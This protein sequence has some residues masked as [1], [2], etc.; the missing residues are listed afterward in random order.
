MILADMPKEDME[1]ELRNHS[2]QFL[3]SHV[4]CRSGVC[5]STSGVT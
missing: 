4:V 2:I 3:G 1:E 5:W